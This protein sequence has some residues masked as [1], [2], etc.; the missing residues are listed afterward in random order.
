MKTTTKL[1]IRAIPRKSGSGVKLIR[2]KSISNEYYLPI[3]YA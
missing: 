1:I 3:N 2:M